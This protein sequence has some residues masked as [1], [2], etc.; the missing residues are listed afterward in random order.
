M[1]I[2][3]SQKENRRR[4]LQISYKLKLS[5]LGSCLTMVD[6]IEA[7]YKVKKI[8]ERFILSNG[9]SGIALYVILEKHGIINEEQIKK[10]HIH[11]DRNQDLEIDV[12]TGS[13]GQGLP[14]AVGMAVANRSKN[15]YCTVS[16]GEVAEGSIWE[17]LRIAVKNKLSNLKIVIN[18]NGW[19][20]YDP[21]ETADLSNKLTSFGAEIIT[22]NGH[23]IEALK[24]G[25]KADTTKLLILLAQ[26]NVEQF[27]FL[28]GQD[29]HYYIMT[30]EDFN[31]AMETL[32]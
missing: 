15:V 12:S 9:H 8:N 6:I 16:D 27:P 11:P 10:L 1:E 2:S 20:A 22:V 28:K 19:G 29:A 30:E 4:I 7:I 21:I 25:L 14:I 18:T 24:T 31:L 23:D 5:H 17:A 13:L 3:S 26:T 32:E